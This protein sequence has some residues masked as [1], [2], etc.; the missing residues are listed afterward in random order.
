MPACPI[1]K[2]TNSTLPQYFLNAEM[3]RE[4]FCVFFELDVT[5]EV[6]PKSDLDED[7]GALCFVERSRV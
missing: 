3:R 4:Y 2:A 7:E 5:A 6:S 1:G